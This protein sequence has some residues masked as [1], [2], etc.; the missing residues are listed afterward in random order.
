MFLGSEG[1]SPEGAAGFMIFM[2]D[3]AQIMR[4]GAND[5]VENIDPPKMDGV[6]YD[7]TFLGEDIEF[8]NHHHIWKCSPAKVAK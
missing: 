2:V 1:N 6:M 4:I 3:G 7:Q 5:W 8:L